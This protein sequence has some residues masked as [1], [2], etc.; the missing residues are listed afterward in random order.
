MKCLGCG[1]G[2]V[3]WLYV[4]ENVSTSSTSLI[5]GLHPQLL[6]AIAMTELLLQ[7]WC[8]PPDADRLHL[9]T[10]VQQVLSVIAERGEIR[11]DRL[12]QLLVTCGGFSNVTPVMFRDVLRSLGVADLLE[13]TPEGDLIL[14]LRGE[15]IVRSSSSTPR[16]SR[17]KSCG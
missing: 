12:F 10:L 5:D 9:S 16:S 2:F 6:Q 15:R 8:E 7:K 13:Q 17:N 14:G 1:R 4:E 3:I 11:A